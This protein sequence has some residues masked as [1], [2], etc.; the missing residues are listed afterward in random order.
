MLIEESVWIQKAIADH[1]TESDFP[2]LNIGS[3]TEYVRKIVQP[4]IHE[5]IFT[6]LQKNGRKVIHMDLK[7]DKGVD[8]ICDLTSKTHMSTLSCLGIKSVLCSN[9]LEHIANPIY[10]CESI[11]DILINFSRF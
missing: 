3:S 11:L 2:L 4:H 8:V 9:L 1:F 10:V 6:P 7:M 5:N